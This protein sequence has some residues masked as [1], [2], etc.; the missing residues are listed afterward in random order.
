MVALELQKALADEI[1]SIS[2]EMTFPSPDGNRV[3]LNVY[4]Q[5]LPMRRHDRKREADEGNGETEEEPEEKMDERFPFCTVRLLSGISANAMSEH[6]VNVMLLAGVYDSGELADGYKYILNIFEKVRARF[7]KNPV[8]DNRYVMGEEVEWAFPD[9]DEETFPY[10]FG[11]F[12]MQFQ[13]AETRRE[14]PYS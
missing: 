5:N 6:A 14:D 3:R 2:E 11:A 13:T 10:Y 9:D 7:R 8:L 1:R 12:Y 4:E